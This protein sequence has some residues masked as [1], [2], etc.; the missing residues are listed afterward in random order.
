[1]AEVSSQRTQESRWQMA[2]AVRSESSDNER[3]EAPDNAEAR[4][5]ASI[6]PGPA[7]ILVIDDDQTIRSLLHD[8]LRLHGYQ[9]IAVGTV[10]EAEE[11]LQQPGVAALGLVITDIQLTTNRQVR[12]GYRLYERWIATHPTLPFLLISGDPSSQSLPAIQIG[13]VRFLAKPFTMSD[14]LEAVRLLFR[15]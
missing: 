2:L 1:M 3:E 10:Q 7:L 8:T 9:V 15:P 12:E 6:E 11:I 4:Q 13:A 5:Q 14:L